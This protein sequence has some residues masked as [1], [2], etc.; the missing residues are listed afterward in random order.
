MTVGVVATGLD[1]AYPRRHDILHQRVRDHF[2][3]LAGAD[4]EH[5]LVVPADSDPDDVHKAIRRAVEP[6]LPAGD[7]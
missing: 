3:E 2:L 1:V 5:Y 7:R 6:L 4:S